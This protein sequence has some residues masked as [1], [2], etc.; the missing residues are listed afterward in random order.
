[1]T[2]NLIAAIRR[3]NRIIA[4]SVGFVLTGSVILI[5]SEILLREAGISLGGAEEISGYVMAGVASWGLSYALTELAHVRIDLI[6][7]RLQER[8]K[9]FLDLLAIVTLAAVATIVAIQCWPVL[10]KTIERG[11]T[12]NTPLETPLWI[13]QLVWFSGWLWFA[14]CSCALVILT[15]VLLMRRNF[16]TA[17]S[18]VGARSELELES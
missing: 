2:E 5:I 7:L 11:S 3:A 12:A 14:L 9:A 16:D 6:R 15:L 10:S 17:D 1:M 13:P 18:L 4:L 8:G